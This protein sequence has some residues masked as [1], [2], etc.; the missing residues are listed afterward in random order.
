MNNDD[1]QTLIKDNKYE[2]LF[3]P[4]QNYSCLYYDEDEFII[5]NRTGD[6]FLNVFSL[7]IRSLPKNG[8]VLLNFLGNLKTEFHVIIV[9]EI[10]SRNLIFAE[11]ILSNYTFFRNIPHRNNWGCAGIYV[12]NPLSNVGL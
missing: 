11:K 6:N 12:H 2:Q 9:T 7:N 3:N 5:K 8:G 1:F 4:N 10:E